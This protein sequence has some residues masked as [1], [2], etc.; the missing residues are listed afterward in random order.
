MR[1][2]K[3]ATSIATA[4]LLAACGGSDDVT[5][6]SVRVAGDSLNDSGTFGF[7][8]TVQSGTTQ[9][10]PIWTEVV[11]QGVGIAS[12]CPRNVATSAS[13]VIVNPSAASCTSHGVGG[14]RINPAG[15]AND[16]TPFSVLQQLTNLAA[17][18]SYKDTELLLVNGGGNDLS[19][20]VGAFLRVSTD[21]GAAYAVLL[22][23]LGVSPAAATQ[24]ALAQAGGVY[25]SALADRLVTAID[26]QALQKGATRVVVVN[27][28]DI[29]KTPRFQQVLQG[30]TATAGA[31]TAAQ[32]AAV[33]GQWVQA[34]NA[35]MAAQL[36]SQPRV[37]LVDFYSELNQWLATPA[38]FGLTNTTL[39]ACPA[40]GVDTS[41]LPTY[42][43]QNCTAQSLSATPPPAGTTGTNWWQTFVFSDNFHGTPKTNE[44]VGKL[45]LKTLDAKGWR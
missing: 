36:A 38:N 6:S 5:T 21:G 34:F 15:S 41:G 44:L 16:G 33:A 4:A 45:V 26:T 31:A 2:V 18:G 39:P 8:F 14:A 7:R 3:L 22:A 1:F 13:T 30:V 20:L 37:A 9:P 23:E 24:E 42:T 32:V 28:P 25:A 10:L 40:T 17:D 19:D 27:A 29:I 35:R 12:L 43:I 11:A